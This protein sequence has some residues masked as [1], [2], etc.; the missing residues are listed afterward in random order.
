MRYA[1]PMQMD[2]S[3]TQRHLD[4]LKSF[5]G[6]YQ[7][8]QEKRITN[9]A[10]MAVIGCVLGFLGGALAGANYWYLYGYPPTT[11]NVEVLESQGVVPVK[12][13]TA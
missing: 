12:V 10:R 13:D 5:K 8:T 6:E 4:A 7:A 11:V 9:L 1:Y 2:I 3:K